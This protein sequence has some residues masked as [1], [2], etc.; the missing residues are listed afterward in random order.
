MNY[1][2]VYWEDTLVSSFLE[3]PQNS[4]STINYS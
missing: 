3:R 1:I 4:A 2:K